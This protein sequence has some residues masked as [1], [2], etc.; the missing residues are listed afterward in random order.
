MDNSLAEISSLF[1]PT[2]I[3]PCHLNLL[4]HFNCKLFEI[5]TIIITLYPLL[6][7]T[8][9]EL[10]ATGIMQII[11]IKETSNQEVFT[12]IKTN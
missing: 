7:S 9:N 1:D 6:R 5:R 4:L 3:C 12:P 8:L 2:P 11:L 10:L